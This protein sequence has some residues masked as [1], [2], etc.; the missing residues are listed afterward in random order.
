MHVLSIDFLDILLLVWF[1]LL[2]LGPTISNA[3]AISNETC[4]NS[5]QVKWKTRILQWTNYMMKDVD[6]WDCCEFLLDK[7]INNIPFLWKCLLIVMLSLWKDD[8]RELFALNFKLRFHSFV[9]MLNAPFWN[10]IRYIM[11]CNLLGESS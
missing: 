5:N 2:P 3:I 1:L 7:M 6:K 11:K 10:K 8:Q 9:G 4:L